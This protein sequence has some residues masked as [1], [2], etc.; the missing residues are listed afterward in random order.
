MS[1]LLIVTE[2]PI[3]LVVFS[4]FFKNR[5]DFPKFQYGFL[6]YLKFSINWCKK[7]FLLLKIAKLS[8][9]GHKT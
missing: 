6:I 8:T 3:I 7:Y 4:K 2:L 5:E 1:V 9:S